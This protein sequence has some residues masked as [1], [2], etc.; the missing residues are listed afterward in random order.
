[1]DGIH[2]TKLGMQQIADSIIE[3][4]SGTEMLFSPETESLQEP[5]T[6]ILLQSGEANIAVLDGTLQ[7]FHKGVYQRDGKTVKCASLK[8]LTQ[9][10]VYLPDD[11]ASLQKTNRKQSPF[12][13]NCS[14]ICENTDSFSAAVKL[15]PFV[16]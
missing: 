2:P 13:H 14:I 3:L 4:T 11:I 10:K 6:E 9:A 12:I 8:Q 16:S 7:I 5:D 15:T 1:M